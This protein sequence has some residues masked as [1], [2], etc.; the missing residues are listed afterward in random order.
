MTFG[1]GQRSG[2]SSALNR[3]VHCGF[4]AGWCFAT[5]PRSVGKLRF[6]FSVACGRR[7]PACNTC[8]EGVP[9]HKEFLR[10]RQ[11]RTYDSVVC[12][13]LACTVPGTRYAASGTRGLETGVRTSTRIRLQLYV[14]YNRAH[15]RF[16]AHFRRRRLQDFV[17]PLAQNTPKTWLEGKEVF[18]GLLRV[19]SRRF[20]ESR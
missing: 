6:A 17:L 2:N 11:T 8:N 3:C 19:N 13:V 7:C 14:S 5:D 1:L 15:P 9:A 12:P 10:A 4:H 20:W 18:Q 16:P